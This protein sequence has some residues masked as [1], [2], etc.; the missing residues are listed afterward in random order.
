MDMDTDLSFIIFTTT[1]LLKLFPI[2]TNEILT[3]PA[4]GQ[5]NQN[6]GY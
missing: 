4:I 3:N 5:E 2:P 6:P 1:A